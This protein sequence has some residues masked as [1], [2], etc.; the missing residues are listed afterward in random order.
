M[1]NQPHFPPCTAI[2]AL[3]SSPIR[4]ILVFSFSLGRSR[5][6]EEKHCFAGLSKRVVVAFDGA[7]FPLLLSYLFCLRAFFFFFFLSIYGW[8]KCS[9]LFLLVSSTHPSTT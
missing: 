6:Y 2:M 7:S 3:H 4:Q 8:L 5:L 9:F 1:R